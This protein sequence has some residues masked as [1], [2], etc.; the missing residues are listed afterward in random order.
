MKPRLLLVSFAFL[1]LTTFAL[2]AQQSANPH[3]FRIQYGAQLA[4]LT[5]DEFKQV[6]SEAQSGDRD[7]Q[8][9]LA[10][11]YDQGKLVAKNDEQFFG[12]LTKSAEQGYAPAEQL[13]Q[14]SNANTAD[15]DP[16]KAEMWLLRGA[17]QGNAESQFWL[18]VAYDQNWFGTADNQVAAKWF[19]LAAE[20]GEPDAEASLGQKYEDGDGVEQN[21]ALAGQWYRRAAE[22]VPDW[23]GAGQGR[24]HLGQL[25]ENGLGVPK[26]YVQA[27]MWFSLANGESAVAD[28]RSKMTEAQILEA[29]RM[30]Q[31]W[32]S[33]HPEP[34]EILNGKSAEIA[35]QP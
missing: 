35:V 18:G 14:A 34:K 11:I 20:Q 7:A 10:L 29:E 16:V 24:S 19:R 31:E 6:L 30:T 25:Y 2:T 26:D 3:P 9:W 5:E 4:V 17:E 28:L 1:F 23:G 21:Y 33:R 15:R 32:K 12:W 13:L 8:Y 22:H 27:Y